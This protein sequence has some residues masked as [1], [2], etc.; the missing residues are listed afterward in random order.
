ML[1][2]LN[3]YLVRA[4]RCLRVVRWPSLDLPLHVV[5]HRHIHLEETSL[6]KPFKQSITLIWKIGTATQTLVPKVPLEVQKNRQFFVNH[7]YYHV[8][9][10]GPNSNLEG[11]VNEYIKVT[12]HC[13]WEDGLTLITGDSMNEVK[14]PF[15]SVYICTLF[16]VP[17]WGEKVIDFSLFCSTFCVDAMR[18]IAVQ[19]KHLYCA[20]ALPEKL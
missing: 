8:V 4:L 20:G 11:D 9:T 19:L 2:I 1:F 5:M 10:L 16:K 18:T 6:N 14:M 7:V 15:F 17:N 3:Q 13:D 12:F